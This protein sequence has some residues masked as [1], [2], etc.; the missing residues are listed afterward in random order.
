MEH[1]IKKIREFDTII[2]H[3]HIRPDGDCLGSQFGLMNML[4]ASFKDKNIYVTGAS[5]SEFEFLGIPTLVDDSLFDN[6]LCICVDSTGL[7][8]LSDNRVTKAKYSIKIDHHADS[9]KFCDYEYIDSSSVSTT[10]II[11]EFYKKFKDELVLPKSSALALYIGLLTDSGRFRYDTVTPK[12]FEIASLLLSFGLDLNFIDEH[13]NVESLNFARLKGHCLE[14]F[15]ITDNKFAYLIIKKDDL[16]KYNVS[17]E[18]ASGLV[19]IMSNLDGIKVWALII[20][21]DDGIRVRLRSKGPDINSIA[22]EF[23]GGGHKKA[24]GIMINDWNIIDK[25]IERTDNF[26][27]E[28][29][30]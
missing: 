27:K 21:C 24:A 17:D 25:F 22:K 10:Q 1:I 7:D 13:L 12:T 15:T 19:T 3:G 2:I 8:R 14:D 4:K 26:L 6:A 18:E 28:Y 5:N 30:S 20:E 23:N 9:V 16:R 11:T 29:N